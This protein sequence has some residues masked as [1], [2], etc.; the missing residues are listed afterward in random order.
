TSLPVMV[1]FS[2]TGLSQDGGGSGVVE[3]LPAIEVLLYF[4]ERLPITA[5][6]LRISLRPDHLSRNEPA[7]QSVARAV[8]VVSSPL[9]S[10]SPG[11]AGLYRDIYK[12]AFDPRIVGC[13][14]G[15]DAPF[16]GFPRR[17][18]D[19]PDHVLAVCLGAAGEPLRDA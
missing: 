17:H 1:L 9:P 19:V 2:S 4:L 7:A 12:D 8:V 18:G 13:A 10:A 3:A 15:S 6:P 14:Q 16:C 5:A 11:H